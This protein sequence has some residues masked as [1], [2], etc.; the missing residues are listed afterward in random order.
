MKSSRKPTTPSAVVRQSTSRPDAD[1]PLAVERHADQVGAEVADPDPGEDRHAAHR[2]RAALGLVAR[3]AVLADLLAEA[4]P[5]EQPDQVRG[6]QDRH[7][8]RDADGDEDLPHRGGDPVTSRGQR[9]SASAPRPGGLGR[10]DQHDVTGLQLGA[11]QR[12][13]GVGV[14]DRVASAPQDPS[15]TAPWCMARDRPP[16]SDDDRVETTSKRTASRPMRRARRSSSSPSS[17][18]SPSTAQLRRRACRTAPSTASACS[19][20]RI[21]SGLAL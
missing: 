15:M 8:Q 10:L 4:L 14:G 18:I 3:R 2:R 6:E 17:A 7:R 11:Q 16:G 21:E 12:E 20:A 13:R 5:G 19:A 1:G 9:V